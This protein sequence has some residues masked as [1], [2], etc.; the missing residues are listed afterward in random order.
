M[1]LLDTLF[2]A[3]EDSLIQRGRII[4][5]KFRTGSIHDIEY[6]IERNGV[7]TLWYDHL[8]GYELPEEFDV[9]VYDNHDGLYPLVKFWDS[10]NWILPKEIENEDSQFYQPEHWIVMIQDKFWNKYKI[11]LVDENFGED[12]EDRDYL[13]EPPT[14]DE[15]Y[16]DQLNF[17]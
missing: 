15:R 1:K 14:D 2:E 10:I 17:D 3:T 5:K 4:Y 11:I 12:L 16:F 9:E 8:I 13:S 6:N 7:N